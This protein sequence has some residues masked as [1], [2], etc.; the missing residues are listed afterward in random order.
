MSAP[1]GTPPPLRGPPPPCLMALLSSRPGLGEPVQRCKPG[2]YTLVP[3]RT[4]VV[5]P[6]V[7]WALR[8]AQA[9]APP[10]PL[11]RACA[12]PPFLV[13]AGERVL[14]LFLL[15]LFTKYVA[16]LRP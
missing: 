14:Y 1:L 15:P 2:L 4:T 10:T 5:L 13:R 12:L 3:K 11:P 7:A 16:D 6:V 8:E 9:R